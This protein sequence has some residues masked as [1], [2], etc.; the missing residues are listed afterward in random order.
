MPSLGRDQPDD[1]GRRGRTPSARACRRHPSA[2]MT[3][4]IGRP[5]PR[6]RSCRRARTG[7][8]RPRPSSR[9]GC[10]ASRRWPRSQSLIVRSAEAE[11]SSLPSGE[12]AT[13]WTGVG[14]LLERPDL[15]PVRDVPELDEAIVARR[16]EGQAV[17]ARGR[18]PRIESVW[19]RRSWTSRF[20]GQVPDLDRAELPGSAARRDQPRPVR[21][22]H[23]T[24]RS[25][26][27]RRPGRGQL[28]VRGE[29]VDQD[30]P[31]HRGGRGDL[32]VGRDRDQRV[33]GSETG[34]LTATLEAP[35]DRST[36][37]AIGVSA[38]DGPSNFAP[39]ATHRARVSRSF[40]GQRRQLVR[41]AGRGVVARSTRS[42]RSRRDGPATRM[43]AP[44]PLPPFL[45]AANV[46]IERPPWAF[47]S[48]WQPRHVLD[49]DRGHVAR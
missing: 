47:L 37:S 27:G 36:R 25:A 6:S 35:V 30:R 15:A 43:S 49:Q 21:R 26:R 39:A 42:G 19:P 5:Q 28:A 18:P 48:L 14:M 8:R 22:E 11:A 12:K 4:S 13:P 34:T 32:A 2:S 40:G 23:Q 29:V 33:T 17:G 9:P 3:G 16:R 24:G 20:A 31:A 38:S 10:P 46:F 45:R 41:H 7:P 1:R 44:F